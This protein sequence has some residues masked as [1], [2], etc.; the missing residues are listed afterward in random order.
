MRYE[1]ALACRAEA[2]VHESIEIADSV[3]G[4]EQPATVGAAKLAVETRHKMASW[5]DRER[6]GERLQIEKTVQV[7]VDAGLLGTVADLLKAPAREERLIEQVP[8]DASRI[9]AKAAPRGEVA[10]AELLPAHRT[11]ARVA[12]GG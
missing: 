4:S 3:R 6:Y 1:A 2:L 8:A 7:G 5:W 10:D 9:G 12:E 11:P